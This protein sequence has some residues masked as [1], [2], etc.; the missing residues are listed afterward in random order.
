MKSLCGF[1]RIFAVKGSPTLSMTASATDS[2]V[3]EMKSCFNMKDDETEVLR[4]SP[5]QDHVNFQAV[6]RPPNA[7]GFDGDL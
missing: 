4:A 2:D 6:R 1:I 7:V 5:V 3:R